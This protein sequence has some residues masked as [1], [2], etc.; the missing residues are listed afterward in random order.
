MQDAREGGREGGEGGRVYAVLAALSSGCQDI[1]PE[2]FKTH[3]KTDLHARLKLKRSDEL[4]GAS[5]WT[6]Y[7]A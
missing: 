7:T 2:R 5:F 4:A 6:S 3:A 1:R